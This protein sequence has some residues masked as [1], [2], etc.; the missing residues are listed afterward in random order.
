MLDFNLFVSGFCIGL[1][2]YWV[3]FGVYWFNWINAQLPNTMRC[4]AIVL[5]DYS[6]IYL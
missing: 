1:Y 2:F 5:H 6:C 3:C 4:T